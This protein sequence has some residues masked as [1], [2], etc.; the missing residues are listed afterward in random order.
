MTVPTPRAPLEDVLDAYAVEKDLGRRTLERY[1]KEYPEYSGELIDLSRELSRF[2]DESHKPLTPEDTA[3]IDR[4]WTQLVAVAPK[5]VD[6]FAPLSVVELREIAK[7]LAV[8]RQ[9]L[10]AFREGKVVIE[11]V[12]RRFLERFAAALS[13]TVEPLVKSLAIQ[14]GPT[15][16]RSY[17]AD[18]KPEIESRVTFEQL[19][20]EAG[21]PAEKRAILMAEG[22]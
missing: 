5:P 6:L 20:V 18:A 13:T 22:D 4:G 2:V 14:V 21:V 3:Q 15:L 10:A 1:L 12:P 7:Q 9:I 11:S 17:K 16:A 8:P 19:L